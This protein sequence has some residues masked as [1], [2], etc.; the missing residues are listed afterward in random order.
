MADEIVRP[1]TL[2]TTSSIVSGGLLIA[3]A[4]TTGVTC[5]RANSIYW[6]RRDRYDLLRDMNGEAAAAKAEVKDAVNDGTIS[7]TVGSALTQVIETKGPNVGLNTNLKTQSAGMK[8]QSPVIQKPVVLK[9]VSVDS[10][11]K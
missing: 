9:P 6:R 7:E 3:W 2:F 4:I 10:T 8:F 1:K 5:G 11:K